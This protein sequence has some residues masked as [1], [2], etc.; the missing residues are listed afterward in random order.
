M[1]DTTT[2][3]LVLFARQLR[4]AGVRVGSGQI[5]AYRDAVA[6][7]DPVDVAD[8]YWA[9]RATLVTRAADLRVYDDV[10][11]GVFGRAAAD[12][13]HDRYPL[14]GPARISLVD[15]ARRDDTGGDAP[16][17]VGAVASEVDVLRHKRFTE[18]DAEERRAVRRLLAEMRFQPPARRSR[19]LRRAVHPGRRPDLRRSLRRA[20]RTDTE[21]VDL[22]WRRRR[23]RPR[24]LILLLDVS[25]SMTEY[26]R[27]LLSFGHALSRG[28][29]DVEVFCFGTRITRVS[30]MLRARDPDAALA[31]AA[32]EVVDW[33]GGT[34]IG[35]S[36]EVFLRRW[37]RPGLARGA[38]VVI[39]SDGLERGEPEHLGRQVARLGRLAY[40]VVWVNPLK[41]DP[42]YEPTARGMAAAL[43][44]V[45]VFLSGHDLASLE[46]LADVLAPLR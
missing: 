24:R 22:A 33:D 28:T 10:F 25:G 12:E 7:L 31:A 23:V 6:T 17:V 40:R 41:G 8:L 5:V 34:R 1:A 19:R 20:L 38:V 46:A 36:L 32:D 26:S 30:R 3:G 45:D 44:H 39:C 42:R 13:R 2:E 29:T 9:G 43:P 16:T 37:G 15:D 11:S 35:E 14:L 27:A 21:L 4:D 18:L